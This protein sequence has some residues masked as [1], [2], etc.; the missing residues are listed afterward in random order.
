MP[1]KNVPGTVCERPG[2]DREQWCRKLCRNHYN[3]AME[4]NREPCS[5]TTCE[6]PSVARGLCR[7]HYYRKEL[8]P[9]DPI[10]RHLT[11]IPVD[12]RFWLQVDKDGPVP[13]HRPALGPCWVWTGNAPKKYGLFR[14][15]HGDM[16]Q[17]HRWSYARFI[18]PLTPADIVCHHCDNPSCVRPEH[19]FKGYMVDNARDMFAK[20]RHGNAKLTWEIVDEIRR[21]YAA[22][23]TNKELSLQF[24]VSTGGITNIVKGRAWKEHKRPSKIVAEYY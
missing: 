2:C 12:G 3:R 22:G 17:T 23:A 13:K 15:E 9:E 18:G 10:K 4:Q 16:V 7:S 5:V 8:R 20:G 21:L 14:D 24:D 6:K 1:S 11:G 19:L